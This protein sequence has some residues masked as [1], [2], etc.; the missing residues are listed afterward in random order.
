MYERGTGV[1]AS[2]ERAGE[3]YQVA[4]TAG[5]RQACDKAREMHEPSAPPFLEGGLP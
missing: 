3:L 2:R 4:C 1:P 5:A